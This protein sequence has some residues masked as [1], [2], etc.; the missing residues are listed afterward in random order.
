MLSSKNTILKQSV[1]VNHS[2]G[3]PEGVGKDDI[4]MDKINKMNEA[5]QG[6]DLYILQ[7]HG[8]VDV[9]R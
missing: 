4:K 5:E 6:V 3:I 9:G 1:A 7:W 2:R 8:C